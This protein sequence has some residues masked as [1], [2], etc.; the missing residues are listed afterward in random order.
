[1]GY[2]VTY[3]YYEKAERGYKT[4]EEKDLK[5]K[6]GDPFEEVPMEKL[7]AAIMAQF[8][9]RDIMVFDADIVELT[10]KPIKFKETKG[11]V[12]LKNK[13]YSF[14]QGTE[15]HCENLVEVTNEGPAPLQMP[16]T[17]QPA[18]AAR[19]VAAASHTPIRYE[20]FN[21]PP[22]TDEEWVKIGLTVGARYE[23]VEEVGVKSY[24]QDKSAEGGHWE[25]S[26]TRYKIKND[27][28]EIISAPVR[29]F[30]NTPVPQTDP[31]GQ[32]AGRLMFDD[33]QQGHQMPSLR[34]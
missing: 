11:G 13:K 9:R 6:I 26:P 29:N 22:G 34:G 18:V 3:K 30:Q 7:A 5:A 2:E 8:A 4:E 33:V 31:L 23:V 19:K 25:V 14:D 10:R 21:P 16:A 17:Q 28:D 24:V 1:M 32:G 15:L 20:Y 12:I 27:R